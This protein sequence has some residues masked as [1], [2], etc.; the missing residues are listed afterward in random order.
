M[1]NRIHFLS[2]AALVLAGCGRCG[3]PVAANAPDVNASLP[4][5][6]T[7]PALDAATPPL[8][9]GLPK[10]ALPPALAEH[11]STSKPQAGLI[12]KARAFASKL[13]VKDSVGLA[14]MWLKA[15]GAPLTI[16]DLVMGK[17]IDR[18]RSLDTFSVQI[19][20][21]GGVAQTRKV[22]AQPGVGAYEE[23]FA[24]DTSFV[25]EVR[26]EGIQ[27]HR[28]FPAWSWEGGPADLFSKAGEYTLRVSGSLVFSDGTPKVSFETANTH[29]TI[30][31]STATRLP[32]ADVKSRASA[33]AAKFLP[34]AAPLSPSD[35]VVEDRAGNLVVWFSVHA[36]SSSM[37][38]NN[39]DLIEVVMS[40]SGDVLH[41]ERRSYFM[42]IA[43]GTAVATPTGSTPIERLHPGDAVWAFD[44]IEKRRQLTH[45]RATTRAFAAATIS[46]GSLQITKSHPVFDGQQ[47][48]PAAD[49]SANALLLGP[50]LSPYRLERA[51]VEV[52]QAAD[53]IDLSVDW[54]HNYFAGGVLVHN[55][56]AVSEAG[57]HM[58]RDRWES[59]G[60]RP[61]KLP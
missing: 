46:L 40:P 57:R 35:V 7:P 5:G 36:E 16:S 60:F 42:C 48:V 44:P 27:F 37:G 11:I 21:P 51:P 59:I 55:K 13:T 43:V 33:A 41:A 47:F 17:K 29:L 58:Q 31:P 14:F 12:T 24:A 15:S 9:S 2:F 45:V 49:L 32:M 25:I 4:D 3:S 50:D 8:A 10:L 61:S 22:R 34:L 28:G 30:E 20:G 23:V 53:V 38:H 56:I 52:A 1:R 54:P 6:A 26:P 18:F 19:V 39:A